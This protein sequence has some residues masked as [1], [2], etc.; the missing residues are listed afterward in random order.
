MDPFSPVTNT[1]VTVSRSHGEWAAKSRVDPRPPLKFPLFLIFF[2]IF[3]YPGLLS[4]Y[5]TFTGYNCRNTTNQ[6]DNDR[7]F[8]NWDAEVSWLLCFLLLGI[9]RQP[10]LPQSNN[11]KA[12]LIEVNSDLRGCTCSPKRSCHLLINLLSRQEKAHEFPWIVHVRVF[13]PD[14]SE[15]M[16]YHVKSNSCL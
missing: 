9:Q 12:C 2:K 5:L 8:S 1:E 16:Y 7:S 14:R 6:N 3:L 11:P 4:D 13:C 15:G 10:D